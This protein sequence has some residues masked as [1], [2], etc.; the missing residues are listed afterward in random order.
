MKNRTN[1]ELHDIYTARINSVIDYINQNL[2]GDLSLKKLSHIALFSPFH[3]HRIFSAMVGET[4]NQF[5]QRVRVEK[6]ATLLVNNKR[7]PIT[8]IALDCGFSSPATFS[9]TFRET[10]GMTASKWRTGGYHRRRNICITESNIHQTIS[11]QGKDFNISSMYIDNTTQNLTWRITMKDEQNV[12][13]EVKDQPETYVAYIRHIGPYQGDSSL[14]EKLFQKLFQW[15]GPRGLLRFPDTKAMCIYHDNPEITD[16]DK[17]RTDIC[18]TVPQDTAVD[19]EVG[20]MTIPAGTFAIARFELKAD[21]YKQ[22]W[23]SVYG[24]WLPNSGY[25]PD[26]GP[27]FEIYHNDPKEHPENKSIVDICIP[28]KPI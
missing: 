7:T 8:D 6:A 1:P 21:E 2:D 26:E 13:V 28:V 20:K 24:G 14:F 25:Q 18:I 12:K 5:I 15:A 22:A 3:F 11:K 19:G 27:C 10:F 23:D 16:A 9:R 4:L 17:L